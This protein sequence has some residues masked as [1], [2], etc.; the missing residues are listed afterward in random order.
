MNWP[1][2]AIAIANVGFIL[3]LTPLLLSLFGLKTI[4]LGIIVTGLT[5]GSFLVLAALGILG[6]GSRWG[7]LAT[8]AGG[9]MWFVIA[10]VAALRGKG[11]KKQQS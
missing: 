7:G 2:A 5:Y 9:F 1:D 8:L 3:A 4:K 11:H 10:L 6:L